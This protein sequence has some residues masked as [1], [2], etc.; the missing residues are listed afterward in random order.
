M[1][2]EEQENS[3]LKVENWLKVSGKNRN[4]FKVEGLR[5]KARIEIGLRLKVSGKKNTLNI[6]PET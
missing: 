3:K 6:K 2:S 5:F 4:W 1:R